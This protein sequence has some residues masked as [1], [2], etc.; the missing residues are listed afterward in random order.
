MKDLTKGNIYKTF[1]LF[2]IPIVLSGILT[3]AFG[4]INSII[5]GKFL[6]PDGIAAIGATAELQTFIS[7]VFWGYSTG[8]AVYIAVLFGSK[9]YKDLKTSL[10][11]NFVIIALAN[12]LV[13]AL[14]ILLR[15]SIFDFLRV[16]ATIRNDA[17]KYF[18]IIFT[19]QFVII[20][21]T[22][23]GF[24][25]NSI[26]LSGYPF[27]MSVISTVFTII[28]NILSTAVFDFGVE[29]IAFT[30]I[31]AAAIVFIFYIR[32]INRCFGEMGVEAY[33]LKFSIRMV[34]K[35]ISFSVPVTIQQVVMYISSMLLSPIVNGI[36]SSA[37]AAYSVVLKIY[38]IN[39][40]IYQN[41][42][43]TLT[44]YTAQCIGAGK[45]KNIKKGLG[46]GAVQGV[47]LVVPVLLVC[48]LFADNICR[49][50]FPK[51]Y[52]GESLDFSVMFV[53]FC[54]PFIMLNLVNNLFHAF[55]R[56]VQSMGLLIFSTA[57]GSVVRLLASLVL[58]KDYGIY[59]I[60][61]GWIISW[62]VEAVFSVLAYCFGIWKKPLRKIIGED[63]KK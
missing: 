16:D 54:L 33:P 46:V 4:I 49:A 22:F 50:F 47:L 26:G 51:G 17:M 6:G 59:G 62:A 52:V 20:L 44:N 61:A 3:N 8:V 30:S 11:S 42:A 13:S 7:S 35:S 28:G 58:A 19:G 21:N 12:V 36:G 45:Y 37:T 1:I 53:K 34:G 56:G 40:G 31:L 41:S 55:Y 9:N 48:V 2:A 32:K 15:D 27:T 23:L 14:V 60:Y 43:K 18:I 57:L 24:C 5:A 10:F 63:I 29:G 39:A 38:N 25:M